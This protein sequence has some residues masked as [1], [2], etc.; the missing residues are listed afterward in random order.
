MINCQVNDEQNALQQIQKDIAANVIDIS[1]IGESLK[2]KY[3]E[4]INKNYY[5]YPR[6]FRFN[7]NYKKNLGLVKPQFQGRFE[8]S[9]LGFL[10][11]MFY[12]YYVYPGLYF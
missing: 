6:K 7:Q 11:L 8:K 12:F 10:L 2:I 9:K 4:S 1:A 5:E 3:F